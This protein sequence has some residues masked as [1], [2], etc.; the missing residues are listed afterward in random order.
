MFYLVSVVVFFHCMYYILDTCIC[1][2]GKRKKRGFYGGMD[3][4]VE[5]VEKTA[6]FLFADADVLLVAGGADRLFD[7]R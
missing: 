5:M 3:G 4:V 7:T 2:Y 6:R 1:Q